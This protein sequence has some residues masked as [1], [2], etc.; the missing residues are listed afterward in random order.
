MRLTSIKKGLPYIY[1]HL[2]RGTDYIVVGVALDTTAPLSIADIVDRAIRKDGK[3]WNVIYHEVGK[4]NEWYSRPVSEFTDGR[5]IE[6]EVDTDSRANNPLL[7]AKPEEY[8]VRFEFEVT[9]DKTPPE[10]QL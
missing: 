7:Y 5:F 2:N 6:Y 9:E 10:T 3:K 8:G 4:P 1:H